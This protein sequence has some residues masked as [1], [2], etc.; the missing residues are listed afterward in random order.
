MGRLTVRVTET[1]VVEIETV[2]A[3]QKPG[4]FTPSAFVRLI[5]VGWGLLKFKIWGGEMVG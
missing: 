4:R 3:I 5:A 2:P 1:R